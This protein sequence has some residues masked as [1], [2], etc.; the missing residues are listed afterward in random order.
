MRYPI[1]SW[2]GSHPRPELAVEIHVDGK[3]FIA[4]GYIDPLSERSILPVD[5]ALRLGLDRA[6]SDHLTFQIAYGD[7]DLRWHPGRVEVAEIVVARWGW[8]GFLEYFNLHLYGPARMFTLEPQQT[9]PS[10]PP[11]IPPP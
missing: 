2:K 8:T 7:A 11:L 3:E 4:W 10:P 9:L 6:G 1:S 5:T